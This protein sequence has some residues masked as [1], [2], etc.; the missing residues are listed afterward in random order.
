MQERGLTIKNPSGLH[1]RPAG[2]FAKAILPF[3]SDVRFEIRGN[4]Y[5]A[6]SMLGILSAAVKRGDKIILR[7]SGDDEEACMAAVAVA[8][9]SGLGEL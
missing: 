1:M 5:N 4:E 7:V 2:V 6:R 8:V 9:E 3:K